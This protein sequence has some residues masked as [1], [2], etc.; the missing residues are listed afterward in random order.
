MY[1]IKKTENEVNQVYR[2]LKANEFILAA[3][4]NVFVLT[5]KPLVTS[6]INFTTR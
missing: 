2:V 4:Y 3:K 6:I 5:L 1:I